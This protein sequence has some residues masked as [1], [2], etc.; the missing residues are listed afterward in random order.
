MEESFLSVET[1]SKILHKKEYQNIRQINSGSICNLNCIV[2]TWKHYVPDYK[3][4]D[5]NLIT[6]I[7]NGHFACL[8]IA[9]RELEKKYN[10]L[11]E[12]YCKEAIK[13]DRLDFLR[14][15]VDAKYPIGKRCSQ[16]AVKLDRVD[17]LKYLLSKGCDCDFDI[18]V[19]AIKFDALKCLKYLY[20]FGHY[21]HEII[22]LNS[23]I[24]KYFPYQKPSL[25][26]SYLYHQGD[27]SP[28]LKSLYKFHVADHIRKF[29]KKIRIIG[30]LMCLYNFVLMKRYQPNGIGAKECENNFNL[31]AKALPSGLASSTRPY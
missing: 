23:A 5:I 21:Q 24:R 26:A 28:L 19:Y 8:E 29:K 2:R 11:D 6:A 22:P 13:Y 10:V 4:K 18:H 9:V 15:L 31:S 27:R 3:K 12:K 7:K 30:R 16:S 14:Y 17:H 1:D 25:C 20:E